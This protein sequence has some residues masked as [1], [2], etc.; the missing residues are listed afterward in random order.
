MFGGFQF[1]LAK[2]KLKCVETDQQV[3]CFWAYFHYVDKLAECAQINSNLNQNFSSEFLK[4]LRRRKPQ[5]EVDDGQV[6][7]VKHSTSVC[8]YATPE[9]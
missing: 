1:K 5:S 3:K 6:S 9:R 7:D 4:I 8:S 2:S